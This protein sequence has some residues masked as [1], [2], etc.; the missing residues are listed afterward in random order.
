MAMKNIKHSY[1]YQKKI[2]YLV[3]QILSPGNFTEGC[4]FFNFQEGRLPQGGAAP[5]KKPDY[6]VGTMFTDVYKYNLNDNFL[7][8]GIYVSCF[9][10]FFLCLGKCQRC[11]KTFF[12][13]CPVYFKRYIFCLQNMVFQ[14]CENCAFLQFGVV[15]VDVRQRMSFCESLN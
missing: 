7:V 9:S 10:C 12:M 1:K 8:S 3:T 14:L 15:F 11:Y 6:F 13:L 5:V 2:I 4:Y